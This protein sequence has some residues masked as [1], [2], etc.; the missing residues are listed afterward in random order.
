[1]K[2]VWFSPSSL[3]HANAFFGYLFLLVDIGLVRVESN[4]FLSFVDRAINR[5]GYCMIFRAPRIRLAHGD[6]A[7]PGSCV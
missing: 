6:K 7:T 5:R 4:G 2:S 3:C 1:M